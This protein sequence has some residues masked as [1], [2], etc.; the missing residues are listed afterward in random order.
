MQHPEEGIIHAWLDGA[1]PANE[2]ALIESHVATCADCAAAVAEARG[3]IAAS[4]RIV[5]HLDAVPGKVIPAV[6]RRRA[7]SWRNPWFAAAAAGLILFVGYRNWSDSG[8]ASSLEQLTAS[9]E[10]M[11][12]TLTDSVPVI[13]PRSDIQEQQVRGA[14][15]RR[16][17]VADSATSLSLPPANAALQKS[18]AAAARP[19]AAPPPP[20]MS[21]AP[22]PTIARAEVQAAETRPTTSDAGR[23]RQA[24]PQTGAVSGGGAAAAAP[25]MVFQR[26]AESAADLS[27]RTFTGCYEMNAST[28][29]L[30]ARFALAAD[31][32]GPG[33]MA[34]NYL[35]AEGRSA[36]RIAD[37]G[38]AL[39]GDVLVVK[40]LSRETLLTLRRAGSAVSGESR[41]G[42]RNGRVT[43]CSR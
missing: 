5:S 4:S 21:A 34:I 28:G 43:S 14:D 27:A 33:M 31:S 2:A 39:E 36:S 26:Q 19:T 24:R 6:P 11:R 35:D 7:T 41:S 17:S 23:S 29:I 15:Q 1:L 20:P 12:P 18:T 22:A 13:G 30:P 3:L 8:R 40:T 25:S 38:W 10:V 42:S 37:V 16:V 32:A 9:P